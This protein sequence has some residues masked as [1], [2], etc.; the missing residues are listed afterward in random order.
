MTAQLAWVTLRARRSKAR[1]ALS[2]QLLGTLDLVFPG[3]DGCF[4]SLLATRIGTVL[5]HHLLDPDRMLELGPQGLQAF[6]AEHG[7]RLSRP[8][9]SAA[10]RGRRAGTATARR[11]TGLPRRGAATDVALLD[12]LNADIAHAE[13]RARRGAA[14]HARGRAA[15]PARGVDGAG[16]GLRRGAR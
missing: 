8:K 4:S 2:N 10:R 11:R 12:A 1:Y 9:G 6:A 3:L 16:V 5:L 13:S 7:V 15:Q 14:R